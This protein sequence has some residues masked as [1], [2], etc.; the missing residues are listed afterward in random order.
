MIGSTREGN[1]MR[2]SLLA[3]ASAALLLGAAAPA[4]RPAPIEQLEVALH[5]LAPPGAEFT[6][7]TIPGA[8]RGPFARARVDR[9][10]VDS[11]ALALIG[12]KQSARALAALLLSY[13]AMPDPVRASGAPSRIGSAAIAAGAILL[14]TQVID[15]V[16]RKK[17][18]YDEQNRP[19]LQLGWFPSAAGGPGDGTVRASRMVAMLNKAGGCSGPLT[20]L[21]ADAEK[22]GNKDAL[23]LARQVR[24]DLGSSIYPPDYSCDG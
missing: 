6:L 20:D 9:I 13:Y 22:L 3:L 24:K 11:D 23:L 2:T 19:A 8:D 1:V 12:D 21:L 5:E 4:P 14:G 17:Y 16:D 7:G 18:G 15:P 10:E